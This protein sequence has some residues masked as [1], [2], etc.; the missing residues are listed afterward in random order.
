[1]SNE[2]PYSKPHPKKQHV[3]LYL[4][5]QIWVLWADAGR[6]IAKKHSRT[7]ASP[8]GFRAL[9]VGEF[10][11]LDPEARGLPREPHLSRGHNSLRGDCMEAM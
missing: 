7:A 9:L 2:R 8:P 4:G 11:G 1:M 10:L 5:R 3:F 6:Y